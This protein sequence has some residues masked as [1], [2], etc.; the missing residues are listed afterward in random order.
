[1]P[2]KKL[3]RPTATTTTTTAA[4]HFYRYYYYYFHYYRTLFPVLPCLL[5]RLI[6]LPLYLLP[7]NYPLPYPAQPAAS[8]SPAQVQL[9]PTG[10]AK[11]ISDVH[12]G[13]RRQHT[14]GH[15]TARPTIPAALPC[16]SPDSAA[17]SPQ[18]AVR[19][20]AGANPLIIA[21]RFLLLPPF[22]YLPLPYPAGSARQ[23]W[24]N[25]TSRDG[26]AAR[27]PQ[28]L[29]QCSRSSPDIYCPGRQS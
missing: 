10:R 17:P 1:V 2:A 14:R 15:C 21:G 28:C 27:S 20:R 9:A 25:L 26:H 13:P 24:C 16:V 23:L 8:C 22:T 12:P 5:V 7:T 11:R 6:R 18:S 19:S 3:L 29:A 4:I